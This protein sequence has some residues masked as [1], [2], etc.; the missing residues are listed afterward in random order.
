MILSELYKTAEIIKNP[1]TSASV[2]CVKGARRAGHV[3]AN[4]IKLE[5]LNNN[6]ATAASKEMQLHQSN[7]NFTVLIATD[8]F[9]G[10]ALIPYSCS[11]VRVIKHRTNHPFDI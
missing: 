9:Y 5:T 10:G 4:D 11:D 7:C 1:G 3:Y 6:C 2:R 8:M